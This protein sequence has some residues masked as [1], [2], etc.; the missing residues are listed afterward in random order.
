MRPLAVSSEHRC[1]A[2]DGVG[3][4]C[5]IVGEHPVVTN[6][7]GQAAIAHETKASIWSTPILKIT[8]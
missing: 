5:S 4:R 3:S 1:H 6:S 7:K 2:R 8:D